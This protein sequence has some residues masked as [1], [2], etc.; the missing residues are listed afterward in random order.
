[1]DVNLK[2]V[3]DERTSRRKYLKTEI[4]PSTA[5]ALQNYIQEIS[6]KSNLKMQLILNDETV[7][8]GF[9]KSYGMF[10]GVRNYITLVGKANDDL[11]MEKLGYYGEQVVLYAT[12]LG[13]GTCWVGGTFDRTSCKAE[14]SAGESVIC[15]IAV[16]NVKERMSTKEEF[17]YTMIHRKAKELEQLYISDTPIPDWFRE[18]MEAVKKAPSA[19]NRQPVK[20]TYKEN[21]VTAFVEDIKNQGVA[22]DLGIAKLHFELGAGGGVW[23][24]GN[25]GKF[26]R[27]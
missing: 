7:F 17:I 5:E 2:K 3:I 4:E 27:K 9:R 22:L 10:S 24:F 16:G 20:L 18:G 11:Q 8:K 21:E 23:D 13:L 14:L 25:F 26:V 19:V 1:M 12:A 15:V 6:G